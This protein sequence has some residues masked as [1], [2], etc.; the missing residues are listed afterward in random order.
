VK[1]NCSIYF[2]QAVQFQRQDRKASRRTPRLA[3]IAAKTSALRSERLSA[4]SVAAA[5]QGRS[6]RVSSAPFRAQSPDLRFA[7]LMDMDF[8]VRWPLVRRLRLVSGFCSST[9][10][11]APRFL[12][13]PPHDGSPC[14][15]LALHLHQVGR[16]TST[17]KLLS[18]PSTQRTRCAGNVACALPE[19]G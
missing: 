18:M 7:S 5:T 4:A 15:S 13:T 3:G 11:F 8:A 1:G 17:S 9:R 19:G 16:R 12:Q 14:A 10:T 6:P 2:R